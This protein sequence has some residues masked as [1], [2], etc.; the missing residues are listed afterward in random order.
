MPRAKRVLRYM[1]GI[2]E[3]EVT[4]E[5]H[6]AQMNRHVLTRCDHK[7][8]DAGWGLFTQFNNSN[9]QNASWIGQPPD[10][11]HPDMWIEDHHIEVYVTEQDIS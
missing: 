9:G 11:T 1:A 2:V 10:V 5:T 3:Y 6:W 7:A 4:D 8:K